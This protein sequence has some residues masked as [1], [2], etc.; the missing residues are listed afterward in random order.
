MY[1]EC[2]NWDIHQQIKKNNAFRFVNH[3]PDCPKYSTETFP[4]LFYKH[5]ESGKLIPAPENVSRLVNINAMPAQ[6]TVAVE[7]QCIMM[8]DSEFEK[9]HNRLLNPLYEPQ[10]GDTL[11]PKEMSWQQMRPWV[12]FVESCYTPF[13]EDDFAKAKQK[14]ELIVLD[15][16]RTVRR[17]AASYKQYIKRKLK[18]RDVFA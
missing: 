8:S 6:Q 2:V 16:N 7:F 12:H 18:P 17:L 15:P 11:D 14:G 1:C 13:N 5:A 3:H 10:I 4:R 9:K